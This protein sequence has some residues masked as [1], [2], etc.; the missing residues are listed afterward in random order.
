MEEI[1]T[2]KYRPRRLDEVVGHEH[3]LE[4]LRAFVEKKSVP[5]CLFA[6]P[7]GTGKTTC[8]IALARE[9]FH[10]Y[11]KQNFNELNASDERGID[12]IRGKV[13][14]FARTKPLN[15]DFKIIFLDESDALTADA[16]QALRRTMEKFSSTCRFILSC[17]F[18]SKIIEPIQSRCAIF[19]FR[20][21]GFDNMSKYIRFISDKEG[22]K[23]SDG[24]IKALIN[25]SEGDMRKAVNILQ[26]SAVQG[27]EITE[28]TIFEISSTLKQEEIKELLNKALSSRFAEARKLLL[29]LMIERGLDGGDIISAI[30]RE[31]MNLE[32]DDALKVKIIEILGEYDFR[33]SEGASPEVQI[34]AF[35]AKISNL[36]R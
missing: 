15:A 7:A 36:R 31:I 33:L 2:E 16:Q 25:L 20:K 35:L 4:R 17:N 30:H 26:A 12:I 27:K 8:A 23:I 11:W 32:L 13:K 34:E 3:I 18:S 19:R 6:G 29:E 24:A 5:H 1:W 22:L 9:L 14:D 10:E 28:D 21:L